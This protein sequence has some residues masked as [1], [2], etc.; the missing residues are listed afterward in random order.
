MALYELR[1]VKKYYGGKLAL[2]IPMLTLEGGGF[3]VLQGPNAAGKTTLLNLLAFLDKATEGE[4]IFRNGQPAG[5]NHHVREITLVM[6]DPYL[7]NTTVLKN[8]SCG[9]RLRSLNKAGIEHMV[10]PVMKQLKIW[11]LKDRHIKSLSGG[12]RKRVALA[13]VLVLDAGILL[14]DEPAANV[15]EAN[16]G[17]IEEVICAAKEKDGK[18]VIMATHDSSQ[19]RRVTAS[20]IRLVDGRTVE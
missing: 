18:T 6:Q 3:Y 10:M 13:R 9:L 14:L 17:L 15:D 19:A 5:G 16:S 4:V 8:V 1:G 7:F 12:E 20:V 11:E 2:N